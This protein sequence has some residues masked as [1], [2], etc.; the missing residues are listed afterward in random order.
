MLLRDTFLDSRATLCWG[1][2]WDGQE[3]VS[4][5]PLRQGSAFHLKQ[6]LVGVIWIQGVRTPVTHTLTHSGSPG[7]SPEVT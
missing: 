2:S 4:A 3:T 1:L 6:N 5:Q 7:R